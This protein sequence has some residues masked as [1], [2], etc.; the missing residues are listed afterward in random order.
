MARTRSFDQPRL[1]CLPADR[2][3]PANLERLPWLQLCH[4]DGHGGAHQVV[5]GGGWQP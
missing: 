5:T 3:V 4:G 1:A 2:A